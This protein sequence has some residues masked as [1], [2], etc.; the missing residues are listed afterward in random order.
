MTKPP[1]LTLQTREKGQLPISISTA[2]A[3]EAL[4]GMGE[5]GVVDTGK[6]PPIFNYEFVFINLKTLY[7]NLHGSMP[8]ANFGGIH[9]DKQASELHAECIVIQSAIADA[10]Q[11]RTQVVFYACTQAN[12]Q[13]FYPK[14]KF[15]EDKTPLQI[16]Y[17]SLEKRVIEAV[18]K[19]QSA[20][21]AF[22][23]LRLNT[24]IQSPHP[25]S[26]AIILTHEMVDLLSLKGVKEFDLLESHTGSIKNKRLWYTKL[27]GGEEMKRIPFDR[28]TL[29][30]FGDKAGV[31][32]PEQRSFREV[33]LRVAAE[34]HWTQNTTK[35]RML[36]TLELAR[37]PHVY[38]AFRALY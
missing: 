20:S 1:T 5:E 36:L 31:F 38:I 16:E 3:I 29:Q 23:F 4:L 19:I 28:A 22:V 34:N 12:I 33:V 8:R 32:I 10:T 11:G 14:A 7:R 15:K 35:D 30:F 18:S 17:R 26:K 25:A 27:K 6:T 24:T 9:I 37:E 13:S 2:L 21:G